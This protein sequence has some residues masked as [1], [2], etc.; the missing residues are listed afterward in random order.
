MKMVIAYIRPERFEAVKEALE[1]KG[2][3]AMS[4][5]EI[6]GRGAQ[7]GITLHGGK[8]SID[9]LPKLRLEIGIQSTFA[10][11]VVHIIREAAWTGKVGDGRIFVMPV[12]F[13]LRVRDEETTTA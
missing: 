10:E 1:E 13:S 5:T 7:K 3:F 9:F 2:I 4:V 11:S 12:D 6:R 8:V